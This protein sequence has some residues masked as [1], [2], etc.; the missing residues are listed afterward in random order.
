[1]SVKNV[2]S[3]FKIGYKLEILSK[4]NYIC[5]ADK[6]FIPLVWQL[7]MHIPI[8]ILQGVKIT[9]AI[10]VIMYKRKENKMI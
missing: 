7:K 5:T 8:F 6:I 1:M 10:L 9:I 3:S 2:V 4:Q